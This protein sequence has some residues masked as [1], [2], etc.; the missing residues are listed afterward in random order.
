M[1]RRMKILLIVFCLAM[2]GCKSAL[3]EMKNDN[4]IKKERIAWMESELAVLEDQKQQLL[5]EKNKLLSELNQKNITLDELSTQID[6]L[7]VAN[8]KIKAV[9]DAERIKRDEL[10]QSLDDYL[11]KI[12]TLNSENHLSISE[13]EKRN[14]ALKKEII[15]MLNEDIYLYQ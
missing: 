1:H 12:Q 2:S 15:D 3:L 13:K 8:S 9:T 14:D 7:K 4:Q 10:S 5:Y 11:R 6:K